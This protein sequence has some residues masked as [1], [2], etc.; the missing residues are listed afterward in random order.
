[1]VFNRFERFT[2]FKPPAMPVVY[3]YFVNRSITE[4]AKIMKVLLLDHRPYSFL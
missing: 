2:F 1:M 3:D 4:N